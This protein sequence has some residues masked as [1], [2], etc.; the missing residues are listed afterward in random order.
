M[1]KSKKIL[2]YLENEEEKQAVL[3]VGEVQS[4]KTINFLCIISLILSD[5]CNYN[6]DFIIIFTSI[7]KA[8]HKQ[9][10]ERIKKCFKEFECY[11]SIKFDLNSDI[12]NKKFILTCL[13]NKRWIEKLKSFLIENFNS[14]KI[15]FINDE[16]DLATAS[17]KKGEKPELHGKAEQ[18]IITKV[19]NEIIEI[20]I[21]YK[22]IHITATPQANLL[23]SFLG[24]K[25]SFRRAFMIE[26]GKEYYGLDY[27]F[28]KE[29]K[30]IIE[31]NGD[32]NYGQS[33]S[34]LS[35]SKILL[36]F[37]IYHIDNPFKKMPQT[38]IL[39]NCDVRLKEHT[40][41]KDE[42]KEEINKMIHFLNK[43]E[44]NFSRRNLISEIETEL[45]NKKIKIDNNIIEELL[46]ILEKMKENITII[47]GKR[48][49]E[50]TQGKRSQIII[51]SK[52]VERGITINNLI[53]TVLEI[54]K[55]SKS[56]ADDTILQR[57]RWFGYRK[58]VKDEMKVFMNKNL[59]NR[60]NEQSKSMLDFYKIIRQ[61]EKDELD[62]T[63]ED[64]PIS[65]NIVTNK[66]SYKKYEELSHIKNFNIRGYNDKKNKI[67]ISDNVYE[68]L[69][70]SKNYFN[71]V[72]KRSYRMIEFKNF[73]DFLLRYKIKTENV[74]EIFNMRKQKINI[75]D[76]QKCDKKCI[77]VLAVNIKETNKL[78]S[79][80]NL[81]NEQYASIG[82]NK[83]YV[84]DDYW[85]KIPEIVE[86]DSIIIQLHAFKEEK[87]QNSIKKV[88]SMYIPK[89]ICNSKNK[90]LLDTN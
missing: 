28:N 43:D 29:N 36:K 40:K 60:F 64:F 5:K 25:L 21:K 18:A 32:D 22:V 46:D 9:T 53:Y 45:S 51:G 85:E 37:A 68:E 72:P 27:F 7:D 48:K 55:N 49:N 90:L 30:C 71:L 13:K 79:E 76:F 62:L 38:A 61:K 82:K 86:M 11:D 84:G 58:H 16:S 26:P 59:I 83:K 74:D 10:Q 81:K 6:Y 39:F 44:D 73:N 78:Y 87:N 67:E 4:G 42:L 57:A 35:Y 2:E 56:L 15:L 66:Q 14:N 31:F 52:L 69:T 89:G 75:D 3:L 54:S 24:N 12:K 41:L 23:H 1:N 19:F 47:N 88:F 34:N 50:E 63:K 20:N 80:R 8:L 77:L 33:N 65:D 17:E 70:K